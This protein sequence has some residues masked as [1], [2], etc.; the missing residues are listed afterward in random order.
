MKNKNLVL[1][2]I[3]KCQSGNNGGVNHKK[4]LMEWLVKNPNSKFKI[5]ELADEFGANVPTMSR[6]LHNLKLDGFKFKKKPFGPNRFIY[7]YVDF[8]PSNKNKTKGAAKRKKKITGD[9][10]TKAM[11]LMS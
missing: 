3:K 11:A 5:S 1:E 6:A 7:L 2:Q 9:S 10:W 4:L 8:V